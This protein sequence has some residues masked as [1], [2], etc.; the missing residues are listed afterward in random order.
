MGLD[1]GEKRIGVALSD[2]G[3]VLATPFTILECTEEERDLDALVSIAAEQDVGVIVVGLPYSMD[4]SIGPQA[5]LVQGFARRLAQ[6][7]DVPVAFQ[8]E[9]LSTVTAV[10]LLPARRRGRSKRKVRYDAAAAAVILQAYLEEGRATVGEDLSAA[11]EDDAD[12]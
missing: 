11:S 9:R 12:I 2:P 5:A 4:G 7:T 3:G 10:E 8:D 6:K 1:I